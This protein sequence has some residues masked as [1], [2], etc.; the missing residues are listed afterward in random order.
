MV[1]RLE[2]RTVRATNNSPRNI[3]RTDV[4]RQS[5]ANARVYGSLVI[6]VVVHTLD[7][8]DLACGRPSGAVGPERGPRPTARGHVNAVHDDKPAIEAKL[9]LNADGIAIAV[10]LRRRVDPHDSI[11]STI[12]GY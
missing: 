9:G 10:N 3:E 6:R 11:A 4:V 12:D 8:V 5:A 2:R 7:D 1:A